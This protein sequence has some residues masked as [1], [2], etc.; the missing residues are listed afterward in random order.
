MLRG[1][2]L[3]W[4]VPSALSD[5]SIAAGGH[6]TCVLS[7]GQLRCWGQ[8]S[9]GQLGQGDPRDLAD[10]TQIPPVSLGLKREAT[11]VAVGKEHICA[12]LG[13]NSVTCWGHGPHGQ[14]GRGRATGLLGSQSDDMGDNLVAVDLGTLAALEVVAG[15][16]QSCARLVDGSLRCWGK[17][18]VGGKIEQKGEEGLAMESVA[19]DLGGR[20]LQV[21]AGTSHTCALL[22]G[23]A[24]KCWGADFL[25]GRRSAQ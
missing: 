12:R 18:L 14:L 19:V 15:G 13:D 20:V 1:I 9:Q 17:G 23:G 11:Q 10:A 22:E 21:A 16:M 2:I 4:L 5:V 24:V 3:F 25:L 7:G 6:V 8:G